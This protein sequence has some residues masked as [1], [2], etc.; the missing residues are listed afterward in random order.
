MKEASTNWS[1][2]EGVLVTLHVI[3]FSLFVSGCTGFES[4]DRNMHIEVKAQLKL[5]P[6]QFGRVM[7]NGVTIP[8]QCRQPGSHCYTQVRFFNVRKPL[9]MSF[10]RS[11]I[12]TTLNPL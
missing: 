12:Y 1:N 6:S 7:R 3:T 5:L 8:E 2:N 11:F 10:F 4:L 9:D